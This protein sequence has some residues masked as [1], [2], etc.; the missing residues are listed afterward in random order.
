M[1][2]TVQISESAAKEIELLPK[3]EILKVIAKVSYLSN[4]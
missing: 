1:S 2:F 3:V 4:Y